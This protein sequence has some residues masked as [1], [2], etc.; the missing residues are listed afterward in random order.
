V[1]NCNVRTS[2]KQLLFFILHFKIKERSL[3]KSLG[4]TK[5][6]LQGKIA[7]TS[8]TCIEI[9][10]SATVQVGFFSNHH[11]FNLIQFFSNFNR[12]PS[13]QPIKEKSSRYSN[14]SPVVSR[15]ARRASPTSRSSRSNREISPPPSV[16]RHRSDKHKHKHKY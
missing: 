6:L 8:S 10:Q 1:S 12:S 13:P 15:S 2:L 11:R 16:S 7:F 3:E 4:L 14:A 9:R 5:T